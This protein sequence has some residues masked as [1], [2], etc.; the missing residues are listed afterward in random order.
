MKA[1]LALLLLAATVAGCGESYPPTAEGRY[2]AYCARCHEVDG[3]SVTASEQAG[4]AVSIRSPEFQRMATDDDIRRI[5]TRGKGQMMAVTGMSDAEI[6]S[7]VLHV[8]R[9]GARYASTL[10]SDGPG[11]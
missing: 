3:S 5:I 1:A 6:D 7:V 10:D 9:L 2:M 8:R 4:E 11:E